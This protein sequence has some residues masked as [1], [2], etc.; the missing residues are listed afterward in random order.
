MKFVLFASLLLLTMSLGCSSVT[1]QSDYDRSVDFANWK[2]FSVYEKNVPGDALTRNPL[3]QKRVKSTVE[4][5]LEDKG[6]SKASD[7]GDFVVVVHAGSKEHIQVTDWGRGGYGWYSPWWGG[8]G[9]HVDVSYYEEGT[10]VIDLVD[11][12]KKVLG[13]RGMGTR[14]VK[15][16]SDQDKMQK[17]I[18]ET[19]GKVLASFPPAK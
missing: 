1:V 17:V 9:G 14:T 18:D 4:Q 7:E 19:V 16:Y 3:V 12:G 5:M 2:S 6:F 13:W 8:Y 10:L 15:N 11:T